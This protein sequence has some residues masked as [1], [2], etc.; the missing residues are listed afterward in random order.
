MDL[1]GSENRKFCLFVVTSELTQQKQR[2]DNL[3]DELNLLRK[4]L[5]LAQTKI[6]EQVCINKRMLQFHF[7]I[8]FSP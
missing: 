3:E 4:H 8:L 7:R 2:A 1:S 6:A 5:K